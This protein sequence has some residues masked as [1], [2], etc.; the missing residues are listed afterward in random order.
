MHGFLFFEWCSLAW[1]STYRVL[2]TSLML[3]CMP[4][5]DPARRAVAQFQ[6]PL[7][8]S[9]L[10]QSSLPQSPLPQPAPQAVLIRFPVEAV[11]RRHQVAADRDAEILV[12][13]R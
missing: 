12:L 4:D 9:S 11:R 2:N 6:S 1:L 13:P 10:P 5:R 8:P 7:P 3:S